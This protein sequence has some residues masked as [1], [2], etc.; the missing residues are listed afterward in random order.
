M[1]NFTKVFRI[2]T[3]ITLLSTFII[4]L[5]AQ[6]ELWQENMK[7]L[8]YSPRYFGPNAF[9]LPELRSGFLPNRCEVELRGEY[10]TFAGDQAKDIYARMFI[11]VAE[12]RAG[13]EVSYIFYEFYMTTPETVVERHAA[14]QTWK[15]G[16]NGDV[17]FSS[18]YKF[19]RNNKRVE[20]LFETS[21][22]TASGTR[23]ADARYTDAASYWFDLNVGYDVH[24]STDS[25]KFITLQALAGFYC[26]MTNDIVH[27]Q[28]D[29]VLYSGG[30]SGGYKNLTFQADISGFH[31]YNNNGDRPIIL[32]TKLNYEFNKNIFSFRY[33]HGIHDYLYDS[34]SLAYI[35]CF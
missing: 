6:D 30:I 29:A 7:Y 22:K 14:G 18:F 20:F 23:I 13:L 9:P 11:P 15:H 32:R 16:A 21:L 5:K 26:W 35:R 27:R 3:V 8:I 17:I 33:K 4:S 12:G 31:G 34:Y 2:I 24:R 28:N 25:L 1:N 19:F 10:H